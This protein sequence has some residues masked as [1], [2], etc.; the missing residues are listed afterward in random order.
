MKPNPRSVGGLLAIAA[1]I[2]LV[3][4]YS[5]HALR[6]SDHQDTY[7]LATRSNTS[8]DITDVYIFPRRPIRRTSFS[9]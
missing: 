8:A 4:A 7:N 3:V 2:V 9:S 6:S 5:T 1:L